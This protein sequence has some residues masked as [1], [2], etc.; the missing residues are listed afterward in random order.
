MKII[1]LLKESSIK[2]GESP[3]SKEDLIDK[4]VNLIETS[5]NL[6]DKKLYKKDVLKREE[7]GTTG[8][9]EGIAIPHAKSAGVKFPQLAAM[10]VPSGTDFDS[11]DGE[12]TKLFFLI[13]VPEKSSD[14]HIVLLQRLSTMLMDEGFRNDLLNAKSSGEFLDII[15]NKE[16]EKFPEDF[17]TKEV[18]NETYDLLAVTGCPTGIAHTFMAAEALKEKAK[19]MGYTMKVET[20]GSTGIE[21]ALTEEEIANAKGIIIACDVGVEK[22]RFSGKRVVDTKVSNGISKPK[23]LIDKVLDTN[24]R[25]YTAEKVS[26]SDSNVDEKPSIGQTIYKHLMNGVSHMLPFVVGGGILIALAFLLDDYTIDPA[27]FGSNTPVAALFKEIG[28]AAFGFM[29]PV[30]AGFIG[31]SIADRPGL[32]VGFVG[33]YLANAG[34][35][36]FLGALVAGFLSGYIIIF[37]RKITK[38]LPKSMDG[39]KPMLIFPLFGILSIGVIMLLLLNPPLAALNES[40]TNWLETM[41]NG[42]KIALGFLLGGMM[43]VDMGGPVNKAAY[44]FGTASLASGSSMVMAA[45][46]AGGM[47]PPLALAISMMI[48][49]NR[50]TEKDK[51]TIPTN[52]IMGLSFI[53]EGAIPFAAADPIRVIPASIVGSG[54]AG[55]LSM[56]FNCSLRAPHGGIWVIGVVENPIQYLLAI[57]IGSLVTAII[58]GLIKK[59][60]D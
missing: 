37:L 5:G 34:G 2:L 43:S 21:N 40:I 44:L 51:Q 46:M 38:G 29:L 58:L 15:S 48:F 10:T 18:N 11:L 32:T 13:S 33:G 47:V 39:V 7:S 23:E 14:E 28:G 57:V 35:A 8:I 59:K 45:V 3:A 16:K 22:T 26:S 42:S 31:M 1:D 56:I 60:V 17:A 25:I 4:L 52:I 30:L 54:I 27:N 6:S 24:T 55:M 12:A 49:K 19:E 9:G 41:G 50:Y 36:G 53:S 20:H